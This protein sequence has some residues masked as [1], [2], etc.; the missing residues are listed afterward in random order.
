MGVV[1][2]SVPPS[3]RIIAGLN[4]TGGGPLTGDVTLN[5]T[6]G[7]GGGGVLINAHTFV[8]GETDFTVAI[9]NA[10][11]DLGWSFQGNVNNTDLVGVYF[12]GDFNEAHYYS[13]RDNVTGSASGAFTYLVDGTND[14]VDSCSANYRMPN[15]KG[16]STFQKT[17]SGVGVFRSP[18]SFFNFKA[19][20]LWQNTA[21][22]TSITVKAKT[23]FFI[24]GSEF[25]VF[26]Y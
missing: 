1:N 17:A 13:Q 21:P 16:N 6:G 10:F 19:G 8:A 9:S 23:G 11:T 12:N 5:A 18:A 14:G 15:Y 20:L 3:R 7:G 22:I 4:M 24:S 2:P 26:G 25:A